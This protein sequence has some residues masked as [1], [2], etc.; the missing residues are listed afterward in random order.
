MICRRP[1]DCLN[2]AL[3]IFDPV[4]KRCEELQ[5]NGIYGNPPIFF[6]ESL[7]IPTRIIQ[8]PEDHIAE[9][10]EQNFSGGA[11]QEIF[12]VKEPKDALCQDIALKYDTAPVFGLRLGTNEYYI[13]DPPALLLNNDVSSPL[14]DGGSHSNVFTN[15]ETLC[16]NAPRTFLNFNECKL[17]TE[18]T[19]CGGANAI[20]CGSHGEYANQPGKGYGEFDL[21]TNNNSTTWGPYLANQRKIVWTMISLNANDQLRQRTAWA[22]SQIFAI[23]AAEI[24]TNLNTEMQVRNA[25]INARHRICL[26]YP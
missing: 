18:P 19:T 6:R 21:M 11:A 24:S 4:A 23:S 2:C 15:G 12:L 25:S 9:I 13:H 3:S 14:I 26:P 10:N 20:V 16:S 5:Y 17:S 1:E 22:I 7:E 8:L